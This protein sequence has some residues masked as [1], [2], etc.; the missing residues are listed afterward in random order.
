[1]LRSVMRR[2]SIIDS[3]GGHQPMANELGTSSLVFNGEIYNYRELQ[4]EL[5]SRGHRFRTNSD[6]ETIVHAYDEYGSACAASC[7]ECLHSLFWDSRLNQI[8]VGPRPCRQKAAVL[9]ADVKR[10]SHLRLQS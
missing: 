10:H 3:A 9:H 2:L 1:M 4:R 7:A 5:A 6:T 8:Y